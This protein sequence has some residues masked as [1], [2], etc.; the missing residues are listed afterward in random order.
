MQEDL[1]KGLEIFGFTPNQA[2]VYLSIVGAGSSSV[3]KIAEASKLYRQDIYKII[4]KLE[5]R[6]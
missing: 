4:P 2:K 5:K 3:G 6:G 1:V